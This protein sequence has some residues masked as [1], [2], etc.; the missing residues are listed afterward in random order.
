M[1]R[2]FLLILVIVLIFTMV[3]GCAPAS[4]MNSNQID[5][6][7]C[8]ISNKIIINNEGNWQ[9]FYANDYTKYNG[10]IKIFGYEF[11]SDHACKNIDVFLGQNAVVTVVEIKN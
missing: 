6:S 7:D 11:G 10:E 1:S 3:S 9:T 2:L 4:S 8:K 5:N